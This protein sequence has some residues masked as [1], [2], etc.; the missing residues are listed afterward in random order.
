LV[1][2]LTILGVISGLS[3]SI[4]GILLLARFGAIKLTPLRNL[5]LILG[6][7]AILHGFYHL[8]LVVGMTD[9]A[10][11]LDFLTSVIL[12]V[13]AVYYTARIIGA[14]LF[15]LA[16]SDISDSLRNIVPVM[17]IVALVLFVRL[18]IKSKSLSS[19]QTQLSIFLIIWTV[20]ELLRAFL[21]IGVLAASASLQLLGFEIHTAAMVAFGGFLL[22]RFY[23]VESSTRA[24]LASQTYTPSSQL[25]EEDKRQEMKGG[26]DTR[27]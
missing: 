7:F 17:L 8:T 15:L 18:A 27:T 26:G 14:G 16:F 2:L 5:T 23:R 1:D 6:A 10:F 24:F 3:V 20:A 9:V 21:D 11:V 13:L 19:L 12:V 25:T 22:F 4:P